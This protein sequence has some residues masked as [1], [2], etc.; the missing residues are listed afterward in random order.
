MVADIA[1]ARPHDRARRI[2]IDRQP[3]YRDGNQVGAD[4]VRC[5]AN[6]IK[7]AI[8]GEHDSHHAALL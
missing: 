2:L 3:H 1:T 5:D 6:L 7:S 8:E 4:S